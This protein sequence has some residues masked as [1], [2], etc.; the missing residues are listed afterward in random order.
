MPPWPESLNTS[1]QLSSEEP[2]TKGIIRELS[3]TK[4][5]RAAGEKVRVNLKLKDID[6]PLLDKY[7][8][9]ITP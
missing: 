4:E 1:I 5:N 6:F 8:F 7:I 2:K 3:R 9:C